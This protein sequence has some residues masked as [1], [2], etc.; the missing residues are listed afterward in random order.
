MQ[1]F[2]DRLVSLRGYTPRKV[3]CLALGI[4]SDTYAAWEYGRTEPNI[5]TLAKIAR[6]FGCSGD[7]LLG[8]EERG[9]SVNNNG[10]HSPV[11]SSNVNCSD[12][13]LARTIERQA[14]IIERLSE[15]AAPSK[16]RK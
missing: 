10:D 12:C 9:V 2:K 1:E 13:A 5:E 14:A 15:A 8:L 6:Y 16:A 11:A 7:Y 3:V 4:K